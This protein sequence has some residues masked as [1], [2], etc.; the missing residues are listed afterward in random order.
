MAVLPLEQACSLVLM[1][2]TKLYQPVIDLVADKPS[3]LRTL[4]KTNDSIYKIEPAKHP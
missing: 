3:I 2:M 4:L 1:F